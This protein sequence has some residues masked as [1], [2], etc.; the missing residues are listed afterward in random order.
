[1]K[2]ISA[3]LLSTLLVVAT[4]FSPA[5][6]Q[7]RNRKSTPSASVAIPDSL[8]QGIP[9][10]SVGPALMS[11]RI[12]DIAIHPSNDNIW[13]VA[14]GSGGVWKTTN[15]GTTWKPIFDN[16][17]SYSIGCVT[18]DPSNP[19]VIWV[20]TGENVG[21]RHVGFGDGIYKS[22]DG[23]NSWKN[24]GLKNSEHL[25]K[26][27]VH[28]TNSDIIWVAAQGPLWSSGGERGLYKSIDGGQSWK[29]TLGN[30]QWTGVT[31]LV[32]DS[33]D[34]NRLYA[35][36][37]DRHRTVAVLL[38]GGPNSGLHRSIDGGETWEILKNGI[39]NQN[40]GKIG[41]AISPQ[42]PDVLYAAIE[43]EL[44][45]GGV[46]KSTDRGSTWVKQSNTISGGTGPHYY[47]E[48]YA[49]PHHEDKLYFMNN[50]LLVS[51]DGGKSFYKH[52]KN[53]KHV[54][55]HA[56]AFKKKDKD[57]LLIGTDGGLYES[58]DLGN[59]WRFMEN[60]P[61]TQ[62]YKIAVDDAEPFYNIYGGTQDNN[63]QGGPSRTDNLSGIRN[64]DWKVVLYGD[65]HQPATEP[66]NPDILY[67]EWQEGGLTRIDVT[68]GEVM[69]IQPQPAKGEMTE[70]FNWDAP[71]LVSPHNPTTIYFASNRVWKSENR[72]DEWTSISGDLTKNQNRIEMPI[73]GKTQSWENAWDVYAMSNYNTITSISE[74]PVQKGLLYAGTDDGLLQ[75][76]DND[77]ESWRKVVVNNMPGVPATAFIND[78]KADMFDANTVYVSLDNHKYG[79][80]KPYLM[81]STDKG[82]TWKSLKGN[83]PDRLLVWRLVQDHVNANLLFVGTEFGVYFTVDGGASWTQLKGGVP[84]I[85]FRDLAIQKREN[86]LI[87]GTFGRGIY[88]LDDYTFLRDISNEELKKEGTLFPTRDADWY[89]P[90]SVIDFSDRQGSQGAEHFVADNPAFGAVFTYYL[91][92]SLKSKTQIRKDYEKTL[93]NKNIPFPGWDQ[94]EEEM[95]ESLAKV[96]IVIKDNQGNIVRRV[97]A[98]NKSGFNRVNWDLRYPSFDIVKLNQTKTTNYFNSG[99]GRLAP[100]GDYTA[101]LYTQTQS[102]FT[103]LDDPINFKVIP[104][105][106]GAL[107]GSSPEVATAYWDR[108]YQANSKYETLSLMVK[109]GLK[110]VTAMQVAATNSMAELGEVDDSLEKV[111][112]DLLDLEVAMFGNRAKRVIGEK[113]LHPI[114][115]RLMFIMIGF[116]KSTYGPTANHEASLSVVNEQLNEIKPRLEASKNSLDELSRLLKEKGAPWVEGDD[117]WKE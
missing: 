62:F 9:F 77:G 4:L 40:L 36:T 31:D 32:I 98:F 49:S 59:N 89:I 15:A 10:R 72:G 64:A 50:Y 11:G 46:F 107:E 24:M 111:R 87:G 76:S 92:D 3:M 13:Y 70:R 14:V 68:T 35:A 104:L 61:I 94:L 44:K 41:L 96:W 60:L 108:Y 102:E 106:K 110:R 52:N 100:P 2:R 48:L 67:A 39:P 109:T 26:I 85:S 47:Q 83:L 63:T 115:E 17:G 73:M 53:N 75:V 79:D 91:R 19:Y 99:K 58:F 37:W 114:G 95:N 82:S 116:S 30:S 54:D 23:G 28:P 21:G 6:A 113:T 56:I 80:F 117:L 51:D 101:T 81:K 65:G 105:R 38:N 103:Q 20:G 55:N 66:G 88:I 12:A 27:I 71:I 93:K 7:K 78:I 42:N 74:S 86:D 97:K 33:R 90:R 8:F 45:K 57:Y 112:Q 69:N 5:S 1:M 18:I 25:S 84:T 29:K 22:T 16:E 43:M 34:P